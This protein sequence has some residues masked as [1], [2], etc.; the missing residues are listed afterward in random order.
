MDAPHK[1]RSGHQG[2]AMALA[3]LGHVLWTRIMK[4]DAA[5]PLWPNRDRFILSPGHASMLLYSYLYLTGYGLEL[6]DIKDF[7]QYES[8]TPGH[9]EK[10]HTAGVEVTTGPL[11][12]GFANGVGMGI[13]EAS[14]RARYGSEI[15]NHNIYVICSDGDLSEGVSHEAASIAGHLGLGKLIYIYDDNKISID[16]GTELWLSDNPA[17]RFESYGWH[18]QEL[19]EAGE[20]LDA[21][22]NGIQTAKS[23]TDAPSLLVLNTKIAHPSPDVENTSAAHGYA[24]FDEEIANAKKVMGLPEDET[25]Y[26]PDEVLQYYREAGKAGASERM[27]WEKNLDGASK[28]AKTLFSIDSEP[29]FIQDD[30]FEKEMPTYEVGSSVATRKASGECLGA[31]ANIFPSIMAGGADLTGNTGTTIESSPFS[32][33]DLTG[34]QVYFGVREHAMGALMLGMAAHGSILPVGGTFLVFSDYM[35]PSIRLAALSKTKVIFIFTHDSVGVGEDGPTH[36]PIEHIA[37][38]RSIP[39]LIVLRPADATETVG[40]WKVALKSSGP[41]ALILTRQNVETLAESSPQKVGAG[42]YIISAPKKKPVLQI[43]ASGSEVQL[44]CQAAEELNVKDIPV[45][46]ISIP[47]FELFLLQPQKYQEEI[48]KDLPSLGVEAGT[49]FGWHRFVD[50][51]I[52]IERFGASA[53]GEEIM[54]KLGITVSKICEKVETMI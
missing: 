15:C 31:L 36:Q 3:P 47:S 32:K 20:D 2:T 35:R 17:K 21:L 16:G 45:E 39:D 44:A 22:T 53:P 40:A 12:Q 33:D 24:L 37:A 41:V 18:V 54:E 27:A 28:E 11:G 1:A 46:V 13:A 38:L 4:Y 14:L 51:T 50:E 6:D 19:G 10:G 30:S 34:R 43:V 29:P 52:T 48:L 8:L 9:P 49:G 25:F 23:I 26:I 42:A 5:F 7:R